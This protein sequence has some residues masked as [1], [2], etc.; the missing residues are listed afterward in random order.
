[1]ARTKDLSG[2]GSAAELPISEGEHHLPKTHSPDATETTVSQGD[3]HYNL[4]YDHFVTLY[5]DGRYSGTTTIT[6]DAV[7]E[8]FSNSVGVLSS[9]GLMFSRHIAQALGSLADGKL[10][11][12]RGTATH[13][14][15]DLVDVV[16][17]A[18]LAGYDDW[19]LPNLWETMVLLHQMHLEDGEDS[20][21]A[22]KNVDMDFF[23]PGAGS[24][25]DVWTCSSNPI[26][27]DFYHRFLINRA[28]GIVDSLFG[29]QTSYVLLV[30]GGKSSQRIIE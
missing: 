27:P 24:V 21:P 25:T 20:L 28:S 3:S 7:T 23:F 22:G 16:N 26:A 12:Y 19:R 14:A 2:N 6:L 10:S 5:E 9:N 4:G 30:R 17:E 1:M 29:G 15:Y 13:N 8:E 11:T 18:K